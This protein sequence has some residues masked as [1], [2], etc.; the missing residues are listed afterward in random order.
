MRKDPIVE[1]VRR[2]GDRLARACGYDLHKLC[3]RLRQ[4]EREFADRVSTPEAP[5]R[6][7]A[8]AKA[9]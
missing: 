6:R 8:K 7:A 9:A 1:E 5:R 3:E 4:T 2:A